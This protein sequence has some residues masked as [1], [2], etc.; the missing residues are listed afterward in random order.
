MFEETGTVRVRT[1]T[2]FF[3]LIIEELKCEPLL[4]NST[5]NYI[6][7]LEIDHDG[8]QYEKKECIYMYDWVTA[9]Q[10]KL[11]QHCKSTIL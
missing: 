10:Q 11:A 2:K 8:R 9:V 5:G 1:L 3:Q 4:L 7:S 6:Q